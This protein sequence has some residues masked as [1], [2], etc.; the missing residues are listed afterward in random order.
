MTAGADQ[1]YAERPAAARET[2]RVRDLS[3]GL[4]GHLSSPIIHNIEFDVGRRTI[5]GVL[6]ESGSGK[7]MMSLAILGLLS[8]E[9]QVFSGSIQFEGEEIAG[10]K[11]DRALQRLRGPGM[12]MIFQQPG[13][14][15][16]PIVTIGRQIARLLRIHH[17]AGEQ[18]SRKQTIQ[19]LRHF[20]FRDP[21]TVFRAYPHQLSGGMAQRVMLAMALACR[22]KLL[23]ADEP[24]TGLDVTTAS[25]VLDFMLQVITE[26][27]A[28]ALVVTHDVGV[29]AK[30]CDYVLVMHAGHIVERGPTRDVLSSP[31]HPYTRGLLASVPT[32][33]EKVALEG[34]P[35]HVPTVGAF[36]SGCRFIERCAYAM[37][38][39]TELPP[40]IP[41]GK[42]RFAR[43]WLLEVTE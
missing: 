13:D 3:V 16:N 7:T 43:C 1:I 17:R 9:L 38:R 23:I 35:G 2:L 24:T 8:R 31:A 39:C 4:R 10:D 15:L 18:D 32:V 34:I 6:G 14:C 30:V 11:N 12:A 33:R 27:E 42:D 40:D 26:S 25:D 36:P 22:P 28:S 41:A 19:L 21:E 37:D 20:G 29:V 5:I